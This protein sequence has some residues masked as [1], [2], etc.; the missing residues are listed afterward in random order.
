M[1][2]LYLNNSMLMSRTFS[3]KHQLAQPRLSQSGKMVLLALPCILTI[4]RWVWQLLYRYVMVMKPAE[5]EMWLALH[6][7]KFH[8]LLAEQKD[9]MYLLVIRLLTIKLLKSIEIDQHD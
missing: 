2:P 3:I 8:G 7:Q 4:F 5:P 6:L 9:K 1:I